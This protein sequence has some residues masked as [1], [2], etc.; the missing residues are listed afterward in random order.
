M[1]LM[2]LMCSLKKIRNRPKSLCKVVLCLTTV[3][4]VL[5]FVVSAYV[6]G[7]P[8]A[9][10][11]FF[12]G[13][14]SQ[15]NGVAYHNKSTSQ[16]VNAT[17]CSEGKFISLNGCLPCPNGTFSFP[18]WAECKPFLNC[19][20]IASQVHARR[21]ILGGFTKQIWLADWKDHEVVY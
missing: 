12:K 19:S 15:T 8:I 1:L 6:R 3:S 7:T 4:L 11:N 9:T 21:R 2:I 14:G 10:L 16:Q 13:N 20:E 5:L 18:G 17:S